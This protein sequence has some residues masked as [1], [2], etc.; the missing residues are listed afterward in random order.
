MQ[1]ICRISP[2]HPEARFAMWKGE[3]Q[4]LGLQ[5][6]WV[7]GIESMRISGNGRGA[8]PVCRRRPR[9]ANVQTSM[10]ACFAQVDPV[11][12]TVNGLL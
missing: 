2:G 12:C 4:S 9:T 11:M 6:R 7:A 3:R 8:A 1:D 5:W 10:Y